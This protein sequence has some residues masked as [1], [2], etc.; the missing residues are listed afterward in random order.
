MSKVHDVFVRNKLRERQHSQEIENSWEISYGDMITLLLAFFVMFFNI[1]SETVN[2]KLIKKDL[3]KHFSSPEKDRNPTSTDEKKSGEASQ[4]AKV[5]IISSQVQN[6]LKIKSNIYGQ[7]ILVE[8]PEVEFFK[9]GKVSLTKSGQV[10]LKEFTSA[11]SSHLGSFRIVVRGYTDST[12][13]KKSRFKDNLELSAAR[14]ISAI[15]FMNKHGVETQYM[16]IAGYGE[17]DGARTQNLSHGFARR[18]AIV[19]EPLEHAEKA[20]SKGAKD[21]RSQKSIEETQA[22]V[23]T[24]LPKKKQSFEVQEYVQDIKRWVAESGIEKKWQS[25]RDPASYARWIEGQNFYRKM[26]TWS[27]RQDLKDRGYND[28]Q[29]KWILKDL[30]KTELNEQGNEP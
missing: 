19:L 17:S 26:M 16:R 30:S 25:A 15:R 23:A 5:P 10:A 12:P 27:I 21:S 2:M 22:K 4:K 24:S 1:K 6:S 20:D 8:F 29:I 11:I 13:L 7:N 9:P 28:A 18:I 14:S 3:D